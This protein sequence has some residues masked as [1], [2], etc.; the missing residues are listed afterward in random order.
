M[1]LAYRRRVSPLAMRVLLILIVLSMTLAV[2]EASR[3]EVVSPGSAGEPTYITIPDF[4]VLARNLT[5]SVVNISTKMTMGG[6]GFPPGFSPPLGDPFGDFFNRY[7]GDTPRTFESQSL[8]SG[9]IISQDGYVLT[10]NHVVEN[11]TEITVILHNEKTYSAKVI[12]TDPKTDLALIKIDAKG[13]PTV[14]LGDSDKL[15]VGEWVMAIGNP[16]GLA[17]TVTAGIVSAK[18]RVIGSGPYDDFIQTDASINPGNSGGPLFNIRGEVVG[19]NTAIIEQGQGLGFAIPINI[20]RDLL[21]Q[22][23]K[24]EVVR[25]WLGVVIQEVTPELAQSFG[26]KEPTGALVSDIEVGSPAEKAGIRKGDIIL[27]FNGKEITKVKELPAIVA[28]TPVGETVT[29]TILRDGKTRD[30]TLKVGKMP[31]EGM[32]GGTPP[33]KPGPGVKSELGLAVE[34]ITPTIAQYLGLPDTDGVI[35]TAV[36]SGSFAERAG[37]MKGDVIRELNRKKIRNLAEFN[38]EM[39]NS[40]KTGRYLFLILRSGNTIFIAINK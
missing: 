11:A 3:A 32:I 9:F 15:Q 20:A 5:P 35:V 4:T 34:A 29:V 27:K 37:V 19:I 16:F 1:K 7:F 12:G 6:G 14:K 40:G 10:N 39:T 24:G 25:G 33:I 2:N 38:A 23:K 22:L 28:M 18:G 21:S 8:G 26:L 36:E 13:L 31:G 30:V 17:E